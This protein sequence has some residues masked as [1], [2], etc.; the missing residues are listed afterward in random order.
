[1]CTIMWLPIWSMYWWLPEPHNTV[2]FR[3]VLPLSLVPWHLLPVPMVLSFLDKHGVIWCPNFCMQ[4]LSL[5][6]RGCPWF[7]YNLFTPQF[8]VYRLGSYQFGAP[9]KIMFAQLFSWVCLLCASP[10][11]HP[12]ISCHIRESASRPH[13]NPQSQHTS[14][15]P[16]GSNEA[17]FSDKMGEVAIPWG[18]LPELLKNCWY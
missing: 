10:S 5:L 1:M 9:L 2:F 14:L 17:L 8:L 3:Q 13:K 15:H 4:L 16:S 11:S 6:F 12:T 7:C 18:T